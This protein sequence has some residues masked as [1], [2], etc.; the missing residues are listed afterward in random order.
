MMVVMEKLGFVFYQIQDE[1]KMERGLL[2]S[3]FESDN[4][5]R[6]KIYITFDCLHNPGCYIPSN[7]GH[8]GSEKQNYVSAQQSYFV[9]VCSMSVAFPPPTPGMWN[10]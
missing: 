4:R 9:T 10:G 2:S 6:L 3:Y 1:G 5:F 8:R 7:I